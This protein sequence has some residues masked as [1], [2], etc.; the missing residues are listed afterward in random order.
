MRSRE[1]SALADVIFIKV[2][3]LQI[4]IDRRKANLYLVIALGEAV[5]VISADHDL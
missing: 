3:C 2:T 1:F 5:V 4:D